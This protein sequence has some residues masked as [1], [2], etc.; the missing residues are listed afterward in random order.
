MAVEVLS[1][2]AREPAV[3]RVRAGVAIVERCGI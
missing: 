2:I 3:V 1:E